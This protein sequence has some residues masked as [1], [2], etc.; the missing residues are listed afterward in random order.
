MKYTESGV[1]TNEYTYDTADTPQ[2]LADKVSKWN[3]MRYTS[4]DEEG[5]TV[6]G[7]KMYKVTVKQGVYQT[8]EDFDA[9][10]TMNGVEYRK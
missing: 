2:G 10:V 4:T 8:I 1:P 3:K 5:H 6:I 9:F 7:N